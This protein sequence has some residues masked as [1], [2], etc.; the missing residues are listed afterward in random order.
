MNFI[1]ELK[2]RN[3][4][5]VGIA[6]IV[7]GWLLLQL[8][9]VLSELLDLPD[10][11][12]RVIVLVVAIGLPVALF[13]A[14]AFEMT[15][16][17]VKL[18]KEVDRS[19]SITPNTGRKL[20]NTILI[21]MALAIGYL[22]FDKL[23]G[24]AQ[25]GSEPFSQQNS[26]QTT[27]TDEK[28]ALTSV[29]AN[30][31]DKS[32]SIAVLPFTN[33]SP[34]ADD[35][36]FTDGIHDDL[37]TQLAK[38]DAFSVISRT[39]VMEYRE[40]TKNLKQIGEELGVGNIM[41]GAVQRSGNRVRINVQLIDAGSDEHLWAEVY[42]R[43][44]TTENLFDI[45]SEIARAIAAAL[46]ATLTD[47]EIAQVS[48]VPT[49]NVS[50]YELYLQGK[51]FALGE[52]DIGFD[53]AIELYREALKLDP[54]FKLAWIGLAQAY[55]NNFWN[56]GGDIADRE[57]ARKSI[58]MAKAIDP[59]FGELYMAEG[60][61]H[62]WGLLDY[63]TALINLDKAIALMPGNA[64][65]HMWKGWASRRAGLWEQALES[66][67]TAIRLN[68]R[69]VI[70]L[71]ETGQTLGY[72]GRYDEAM[73]L[74]EKAYEVDPD[75]FWAKSYLATT[76]LLVDGD[77]QRARTLLVGAQHT[78]DYNFLY[79]YWETQ[80]L[81][82][83]FVKA[84][85]FVKSWPDEVEVN[86]NFFDLR[87][88]LTAETLLAMGRESDAKAKA[89]EG[90]ARLE[91]MKQEGLDDFRVSEQEAVAYSILGDKLKV[92]EAIAKVVATRPP[93]AVEE[94]RLKYWYAQAYARADMS[95]ECI[96]TL[97]SLL[98]GPSTISIP[99][100]DLDPAFN[101]IRD[102]PA[103]IGLLERHR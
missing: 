48:D 40:T 91:K 62:Y 69:V 14:W 53:T 98:S 19:Q 85:E 41:E 77:T 58:D 99:W 90:L 16:E 20:N 71:I 94:L 6:Y 31:G 60:F 34:N 5:R 9:D 38:I 89:V 46:K 54:N 100:L 103:F 72:L 101:G 80:M 55:I 37:L 1:A 64:E 57:N 2:R 93:D 4:F 12:G 59:D 67:Q 49:N 78:K 50:A 102:N 97:D 92:S 18:E 66:M 87:E 83:D 10:V 43:E 42:D 52:T 7:G 70:N 23:S 28:R 15:P 27:E 39:S 3:V 86:L 56:Y 88:I 75:S 11:V 61:Y 81:A 17:G 79:A 68:P 76:S 65:T 33:R 45:Q 26:S 8:T 95:N 96:S 63:D 13:F 30:S 35:A 22:L 44:L 74:V 47:N 29:E 24:P 73:T 51:R 36:Y 25:P 21:M 82:G 84:L 32:K